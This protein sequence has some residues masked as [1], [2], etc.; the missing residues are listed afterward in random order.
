MNDFGIALHRLRKEK[1]MSLAQ[2]SSAT[3]YSK[4]YLSK[5][6]SGVRTA[7]ETFARTCDNV[8]GT[9][10][11]LLAVFRES[12]VAKA[13]QAQ[14]LALL[15]APE[16]PRD[17]RADKFRGS[18]DVYCLQLKETDQTLR[19]MGHYMSPE[20][21]LPMALTN[22]DTANKVL[23]SARP[24]STGELLKVVASI[25]EYA[26]WMAQENGQIELATRLTEEA[27]AVA[28][29]AGD[30]RL[31]VWKLIRSAD[32]ALY[33]GDGLT[34]VQLTSRTLDSEDVDTHTRSVA[35]QR[36]AQGHALLGDRPGCLYALDR[37]K[38]FHEAGKAE[39]AERPLGTTSIA[40]PIE[41]T[42]GWALVDL[43]SH[44]EAA[45]DLR[46]VVS[47]IAPGKVRSRVRFTT[48]LALAYASCGDVD[49]AC[50]T[51]RTV[52]ADIHRVDSDTVR[53]DLRALAGVL[54]HRWSRN[55]LVIDL[56]SELKPQLGGS[57]GVG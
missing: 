13:E 24:G 1:G 43:C 48:R 26:G 17:D 57:A 39:E 49:Q 15:P 29:A 31:K 53:V 25:K 35:W 33:R 54:Q 45:V 6:E 40:H 56:L 36:R 21:I 41:M 5:L 55:S 19:R 47:E 42:R 12:E 52:L 14:A 37:A 28:E 51:I 32:I 2:L 27:A 30:P 9:D 20:V 38:A 22:V 50:E 7:T 18:V 44:E 16:A 8:L 11:Q 3:H 10:G 34:I 23:R 4:G 46:K